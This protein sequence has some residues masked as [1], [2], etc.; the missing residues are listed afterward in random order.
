MD[1][2]R[3]DYVLENHRMISPGS[4]PTVNVCLTSIKSSATYDIVVH[5]WKLDNRGGTPLPRRLHPLWEGHPA[6]TPP[7]GT[8]L[9][10][11]WEGHPAATPR[12]RT[13]LMLSTI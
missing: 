11:E 2:V 10:A 12:H 6:A 5:A 7:H 8:D 9:Y 13:D 4:L 1:S 3:P